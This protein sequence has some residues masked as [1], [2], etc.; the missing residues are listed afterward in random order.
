VSGERRVRISVGQLMNVRDDHHCFGC[1][2]L[3]SHGLQ[4]TFYQGEDGSLWAPWTP[5]QKH[6]GYTGIAHGGVITAV[7]DEVMAWTVYSKQIWAVTGRINVTFR[8]PVE[9]GVPT[10][11]TGRIVTDRG[12][13]LEMAAS[14]HRASDELLLAEA[15]A[16]FIR[17]PEE[18]ASAWR[19]RYLGIPSPS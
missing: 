10:R 1:G 2:R 12:R 9:M 14:L 15:T 6:E 19:E 16:T 3:N 13:L 11:A 8:K 7:L 4:L 5:D 18:Q 17:V